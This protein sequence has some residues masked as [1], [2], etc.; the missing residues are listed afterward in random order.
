[1]VVRLEAC[2]ESAAVLSGQV[3]RAERSLTDWAPA[4]ATLPEVF[5]RARMPPLR[6]ARVPPGAS[7]AGRHGSR[8]VGRSSG[9]KK[10]AVHAEDHG[11]ESAATQVF[12]A[13]PG[14]LY[15][16]ATPIGNLRDV[17]LRALDVL[18]SAAI[19]AAEDTRVSA[20]LLRHFGIATTML[21]L[22][23]HNERQRVR[24]VL[25]ALENGKS[26]ALIT[27]AGTPGVSD[28]GAVLVADVRAAGY[29]VVP[30]PGASAAIAALSASGLRAERFA[31]VG[32]L[33][34]QQ[35]ARRTLL[36]DLAKLKLALVFY[37]AP[38]RVRA[39]A[40]DLARALGS[41]RVL[42]VA[43]E[44]TKAFE[45]IA[46]MPLAQA[47]A[48]FDGDANRERGEFVLLVDEPP[49]A[50]RGSLSREAELWIDALVRELSP[51]RVARIV[52]DRT[53]APRDACYERALAAKAHGG[54]QTPR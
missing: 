45:T 2:P 46:T 44:L 4:P 53:G 52:A 5:A 15:V 49:D 42:V 12:S 9:A 35:K 13:Q 31:F 7:G 23:A 26:V 6:A 33:P 25:D 29:S 28:P 21:S 37:E 24:V 54:D 19:I 34:Q 40:R 16:V 41:E 17:T 18:R 22:H 14:S 43:R 10:V 38:H 48:W 20:N 51:A 1:M 30:I 39:T 32:F 27:D 11:G 47:E 36:G 3:L 8:D 50:A